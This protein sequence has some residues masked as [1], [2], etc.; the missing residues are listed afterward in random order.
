MKKKVRLSA[1]HW[2]VLIFIIAQVVAFAVISQEN[3][4]LESYHVY[5][6][7]QSPGQRRL[8]EA[9]GKGLYYENG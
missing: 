6:P 7:P 4:F 2:A 1:V 9:Q 5:V 8:V 3:A